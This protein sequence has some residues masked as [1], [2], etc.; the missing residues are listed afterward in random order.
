MSSLWFAL[1]CL[2]IAAAAALALS[3]LLRGA[4]VRNGPRE[5]ERSSEE[6]PPS[7]ECRVIPLTDELVRW[8]CGHD[9]PAR[10]RHDFYGT[11]REPKDE[12]FEEKE[13]CGDCML[14]LNER[15]VIRCV[16]CGHA[17]FP[18]EPVAAYGDDRRFKK[19][20]K[21][22]ADEERTVVIGC[23]R[24]DCC[25]SGGFFSGTWTGRGIKSPFKTGSAAGDAFAAGEPVFVNIGDENKN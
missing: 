9:A 10:F 8:A 21:T 17:I 11:V 19:T 12:V 13:D 24:W 4:R 16:L 2:L 23:M 25:P 7:D 1:A 15:F 18:G 14:A 20:W 3:R 22:Y 5:A 6:R